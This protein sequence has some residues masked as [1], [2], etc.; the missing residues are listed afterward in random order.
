MTIFE[1][2]K[3]LPLTIFLTILIWMYAEA[4]VNSVSRVTA[5]VPNI[6][7][8]VSAPPEILNKYDVQIE[9][10]SVRLIVSGEAG[11]I[12][13]LRKRIEAGDQDLGIHAILDVNADDHPSPAYSSRSVRCPTPEGLTLQEKP[14]NVSFRLQERKSAATQSN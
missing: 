14:P 6:P 5:T 1:R 7:V 12:D 2:L 11:T 9:P 4:Q 10:A 3:T 8:W 13:A